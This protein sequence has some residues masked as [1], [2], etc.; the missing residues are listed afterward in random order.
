MLQTKSSEEI[1][2]A[3]L[4]KSKLVSQVSQ[5]MLSTACVT[6]NKVTGFS[7]SNLI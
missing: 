6:V 1:A 3:L 5:V 4:M 2:Q 7:K